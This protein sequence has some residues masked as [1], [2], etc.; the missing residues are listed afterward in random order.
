M[1]T[2]NWRVGVVA[3]FIAGVSFAAP[4]ISTSGCTEW[5]TFS[6]TPARSLLYRTYP[7]DTRND[8]ITRAFIMVHGAG[9]DADNY[10]R[11]AI[12]AAFLGGALEDTMVIS[13]RFAS[14]DGRG[15][16]DKLAANEVSW[17][18]SGDSWRSV[19]IST[20]NDWLTSYDLAD[21]ILCK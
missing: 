17:S 3:F 2:V 20:T 11:T 14:N 7:L 12:A 8:G 5:V 21:D 1:K 13:P 9:R 10:F 15:C 16:R 19:G 4:C 18:C 6:G